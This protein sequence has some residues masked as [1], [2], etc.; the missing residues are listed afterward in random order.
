MKNEMNTIQK[1]STPDSDGALVS[2]HA[3]DS[4]ADG[5]GGHVR[6]ELGVRLLHV[7]DHHHAHEP[8]QLDLGPVQM[9]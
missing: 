3:H 7:H 9:L 5:F 2:E 4:G 6:D 8:D 1:K